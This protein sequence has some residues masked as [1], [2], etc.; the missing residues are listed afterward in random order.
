MYV[1]DL[2]QTGA[3]VVDSSVFVSIYET[4]FVDSMWYFILVSLAQTL[5]QSLI[6]PFHKVP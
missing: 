2:G 6:F 5:L 3:D 1:Q 4:W